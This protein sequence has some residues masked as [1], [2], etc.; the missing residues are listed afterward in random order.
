MAKKRFESLEK[1]LDAYMRG[2]SYP[3]EIAT[4]FNFV[5]RD[6]FEKMGL[7]PVFVGEYFVDP[8]EPEQTRV[9]CHQGTEA[10]S[11]IPI[12]R[13]V[14]GR[15][16]R[17]GED[18]YVPDVTKDTNHVSCDPDMEGSELVLISWSDPYKEGQYKG[19]S[20]PL[21]VL[22]IDFNVKEA[23]SEKEIEGLR[24]TWDKYGKAI[25]PGEP[26]FAPKGELYVKRT[27]GGK[28]G[29]GEI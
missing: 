4:T 8:A 17:T 11:P 7:K 28:T 2:R 13:G 22:D 1:R 14:M 18:Q 21:G 25:F 29:G 20:I 23:L 9:Y 15:A 16:V 3:S 27:E 12:K 6:E 26:A 24:G 5:L 10:C 19:C